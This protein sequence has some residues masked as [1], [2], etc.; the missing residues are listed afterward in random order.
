M[1]LK[2]SFFFYRFFYCLLSS[3]ISIILRIVGHD[4]KW[5]EHKFSEKRNYAGKQKKL[6]LPKI[7]V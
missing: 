3:E 5:N 2:N 6:I 7:F 1:K 4:K